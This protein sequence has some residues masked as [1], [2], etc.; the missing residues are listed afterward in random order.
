VRV[1]QFE[2][3]RIQPLLYTPDYLQGK[4]EGEYTSD[5]LQGKLKGEYCYSE[6]IC[7]ENLKMAIKENV[8]KV[9]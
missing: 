8:L 2:E 6:D 5:Y 9:L 1:L 7:L 4:L 3:I